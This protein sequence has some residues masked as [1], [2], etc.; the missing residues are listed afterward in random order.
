M[1]ACAPKRALNLPWVHKLQDPDAS[2]VPVIVPYVPGV[3][4]QADAASLN[5]G[6]VAKFGH[7]LHAAFPIVALNCPAKHCEHHPVAK[8]PPFMLPTYATS[9]RQSEAE[10]L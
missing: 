4:S 1:H 7:V 2:L 5:T 3:H 6:E 9:Q 10:S 8:A